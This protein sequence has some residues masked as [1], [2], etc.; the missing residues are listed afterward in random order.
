MFWNLLCSE[1]WWKRLF[2]FYC[3]PATKVNIA[4]KISAYFLRHQRVLDV[5]PEYVPCLWWKFKKPSDVNV[6]R[7]T[8]LFRFIKRMNLTIDS[9]DVGPRTVHKMVLFLRGK[10]SEPATPI[11]HL[12]LWLWTAVM[13]AGMWTPGC[14]LSSQGVARRWD[15]SWLMAFA[16]FQ[17]QRTTP[18]PTALELSFSYCCIWAV[19]ARHSQKT[20]HRRNPAG[21]SLAGRGSGHATRCRAKAGG[22]MQEAVWLQC[23][24]EPSTCAYSKCQG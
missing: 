5:I 18:M 2:F 19:P 7:K 8:I 14:V 15:G 13:H 24:D 4:A 1:A 10:Q 12:F 23:K 6:I 21:Y 11:H 3:T 22:A 9:V 17:T 16:L 20:E